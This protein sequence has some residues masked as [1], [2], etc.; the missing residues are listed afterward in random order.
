MK[1]VPA[2]FLAFL[3]V[4]GLAASGGNAA[5]QRHIGFVVYGAANQAIIPQMAAV[6]NYIE[7]QGDRYTLLD[8]AFNFGVMPDLVDQL[9]VQDVDG[10]IVMNIFPDIITDAVKRAN[11]KNIPVV[12]TD[13]GFNDPDQTL[14]AGQTTSDNYRAG[15]LVVEAFVRD[16][17]P[18][19]NVILLTA[20]FTIPAEE[21]TRAIYETIAKYPGIKVLADE[22]VDVT[23]A[24]SLTA[25]EN[26]LQVHG[27]SNIDAIFGIFG[28]AAIGAI[29]ASQA[30]GNTHI[31][32]YG[33]DASMD[34]LNIIKAGMQM[35][36]VAQDF[37]M[38]GNSGIIKLYQAMNGE[39]IPE[40]LTY[41]P[42]EYID[43]SNVDEYMAKVLEQQQQ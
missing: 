26:L 25:V 41:V 7:A 14:L 5:E 1:K 15:E 32:I 10:I 27:G 39:S 40:Y 23:V 17:G 31:K 11:E 2:I 13:C 20:L 12:V 9:I 24:L 30:S 21:R 4:I 36:S 19:G 37:F 42:V 22:T 3:L 8:A 6:T 28:N 29:S 16:H 33:I 34:E 43:A 38:L 35:G 18:E